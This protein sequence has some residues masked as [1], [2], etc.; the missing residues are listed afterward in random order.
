MN[1]RKN[2]LKSYQRKK[3]ITSMEWQTESTLHQLQESGQRSNI[4]VEEKNR[5]ESQTQPNHK[6]R[7]NCQVLLGK[8]KCRKIYEQQLL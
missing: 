3:Q 2:I 1:N 5:L 7:M 8:K 6:L 4:H